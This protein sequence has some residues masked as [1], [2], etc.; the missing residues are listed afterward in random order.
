[1]QIFLQLSS[2]LTA[3]VVCVNCYVCEFFY[4]M[5]AVQCNCPWIS[6]QT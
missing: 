2:E 6:K 3:A 1:M 4:I 5:L